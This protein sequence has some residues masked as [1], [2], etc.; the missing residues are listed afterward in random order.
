MREI[1]RPFQV[2]PVYPK[3]VVLLQE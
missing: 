2:F 3:H 1:A